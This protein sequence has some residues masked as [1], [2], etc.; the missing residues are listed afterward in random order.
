MQDVKMP[1]NRTGL[2][3]FSSLT[4]S[5]LSFDFRVQAATV[6]IIV[7]VIV[8]SAAFTVAFVEQSKNQNQ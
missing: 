1:T 2:C 4:L 8:V 5:I 3:F 6:V 7:V